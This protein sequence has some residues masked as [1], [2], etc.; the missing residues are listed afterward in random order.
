MCLCY[1]VHVTFLL[2]VLIDVPLLWSGNNTS[3][4]ETAIPLCQTILWVFHK[5]RCWAQCSFFCISMTCTDPQIRCI[6]AH[7]RDDTTVFAS[8]SDIINVHATVNR[9]LVG[10]DNWLKANRLSIN[11]SKISYIS[12]ISRQLLYR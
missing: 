6:F 4:S 7:F 10:V 8:D 12:K 3:Q 2:I 5:G 11:V 9:E 1:G